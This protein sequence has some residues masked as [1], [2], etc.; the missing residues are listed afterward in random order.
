MLVVLSILSHGLENEAL[1]KFVD[2]PQLKGE[3]T[4]L[5]L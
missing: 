1:V 2:D 3:V 4:L 5:M